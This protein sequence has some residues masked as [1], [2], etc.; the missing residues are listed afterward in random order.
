M[1][2]KLFSG[3][4]EMLI[5][6]VISAGPTYGYQIA[7]QVEYGSK[8]RDVAVAP[9]QS[10]VCQ[11]HQPADRQQ[12]DHGDRWRVCELRQVQGI[13]DQDQPKDADECGWK[14]E[15]AHTA[16]YCVRVIRVSQNRG[17]LATGMSS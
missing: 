15:N 9:S 17:S 11:V 8:L 10:P 6:E 13:S 12:A 16:M 2:S 14:Q 3:T 7:Q 5:L 4:L 1:D